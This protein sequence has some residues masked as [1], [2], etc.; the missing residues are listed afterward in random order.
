MG[1]QDETTGP[2]RDEGVGERTKTNQTH[3]DKQT[4]PPLSVDVR[5]A[6]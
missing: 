5:V 6:S 4:A 2:S 1:K 3:L